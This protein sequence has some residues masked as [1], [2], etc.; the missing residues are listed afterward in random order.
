VVV[1]DLRDHVARARVGDLDAVDD[2]A[3]SAHRCSMLVP[4]CAN[5]P[6]PHRRA[7]LRAV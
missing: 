7:N 1:P 4:P 2:Q 5:A 6:H 3:T